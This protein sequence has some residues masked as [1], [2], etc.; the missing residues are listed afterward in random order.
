[1]FIEVNMFALILYC[2]LISSVVSAHFNNDTTHDRDELDVNSTLSTLGAT[3]IPVSKDCVL[4]M[5]EN[6]ISQ[7]VEL[8]NSAIVNVVVIHISFSNRTHNRQLFS[9]FHVSL[10]NHYRSGNSART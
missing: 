10:S 1:M 7:I 9:D 5:K 4:E 2:G 8:L 3:T 6:E